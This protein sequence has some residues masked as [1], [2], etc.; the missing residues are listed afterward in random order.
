MIWH[1]IAKGLKCEQVPVR[2]ILT[3]DYAE[4]SSKIQGAAAAIDADRRVVAD[5]STSGGYT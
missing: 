3:L 4:R 5:R 1:T 2:L